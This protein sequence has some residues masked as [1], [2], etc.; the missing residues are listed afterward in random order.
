MSMNRGY[1]VH[2]G[3][4][5]ILMLMLRY[6]EYGAHADEHTMLVHMNIWCTCHDAY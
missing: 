1:F 4:V 6:I 5:R 2:N 3:V